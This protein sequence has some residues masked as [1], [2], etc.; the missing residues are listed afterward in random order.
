MLHYYVV[1]IIIILLIADHLASNGCHAASELFFLDFLMR[2]RLVYFFVQFSSWE[3]GWA[4]SCRLAEFTTSTTMF[5]DVVVVIVSY[6]QFFH[7]SPPKL[8]MSSL[9]MHSFSISLIHSLVSH[10]L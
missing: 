5:S 4:T 2:F 1:V 3:T 6:L 9:P 8:L 7:D 10:A